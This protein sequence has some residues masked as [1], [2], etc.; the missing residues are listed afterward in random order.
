MWAKNREAH[1]ELV[2]SPPCP[3]EDRT[4][5]GSGLAP[6]QTPV[7]PRVA[8]ES[9]AFPRSSQRRLGALWPRP[10]RG[11]QP[12]TACVGLRLQLLGS[13]PDVPATLVP[14]VRPRSWRPCAHGPMRLPAGCGVPGRR[15][16]GVRCGGQG[17][18]RGRGLGELG[19]MKEGGGSLIHLTEQK[20]RAS[21]KG[22]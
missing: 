12:V 3:G 2:R 22:G 17:L 15:G 5:A 8:G 19:S 9:P 21:R 16:K 7:G 13:F 1:L 4:A 14:P 18:R 20:L 10:A 6:S 11:G